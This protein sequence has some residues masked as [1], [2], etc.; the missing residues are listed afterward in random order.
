MNELGPKQQSA[1][2]MSPNMSQSVN[3]A[4]MLLCFITVW[5]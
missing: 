4:K 3:I 2:G 5:Q 1:T